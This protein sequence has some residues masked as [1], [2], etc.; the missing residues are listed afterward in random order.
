MKKLIILLC[1]GA[2]FLQTEAQ[3]KKHVIIISIDGFRPD[4][5]REA[6]WPTPILQQLA[7]TGVSADGVRGVFPSVTYPSHTTIIT[8]KMPLDHGIYYNSPFEPYGATGRWYWETELIQTPTLWSLAEDAGLKT[9]SVFWPVSVG[10]PVDYNIPEFWSI[11]KKIDR[12]LPIRDNAKPKGL[13]EEIEQ[14]ATG[15]LTAVDLNSDFLSADEN[16]SRMVAYLIK[17][18]QPNLLTFHIF[19]VDHASHAEGRDGEM[20]RK[21]VAGADHA[22]GNILEAIE[23]AGIKENTSVIIT[24]DHGFV[25]VNK[26][27]SPNVLLMQKGIIAD[28][29]AKANWSAKFHTSGAAAFLHL[30]QKDDVKVVNDVR[31]LL[32]A[33][34]VAQKKLF[35]IVERK[36][37]DSIGTDPNVALALAPIEGY[38]MS[39]VTKGD[40]IKPAKG[41]TH[42]FFP[43]FKNIETGFIGY[44]AAFKKPSV[45]PMMGLEDIAPIVSKILNLKMRTLKPSLEKYI[46]TNKK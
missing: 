39:S 10:A 13:F 15:K 6:K 4:F 17:K 16:G 22:V 43:D 27:L 18:H 42:G 25:D 35:R 36:E 45:I 9:A 32:N 30:N 21:A 28:T 23:Q 1:L 44:G 46:F 19:S 34:P 20:V 12:L 11:D 3:E 38:S 26:S 24:G 2:T 5:Y 14:N 40:F 8:G 7:K 33:L 37:L 31:A 41:G 29:T